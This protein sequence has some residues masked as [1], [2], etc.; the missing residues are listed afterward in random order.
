MCR[1]STKVPLDGNER[2]P[3][4][5]CESSAGRYKNTM[6]APRKHHNFQHLNIPTSQHIDFSTQHKQDSTPPNRCKDIMD[7]SRPSP[8]GT[9]HFFQLPAELRNTIYEYTLT[10]S[11]GVLCREEPSNNSGIFR[12]YAVP[13]MERDLPRKSASKIGMQQNSDR[14]SRRPWRPTSSN[15]FA[16]S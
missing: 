9:C 5:L 14:V 1:R 8:D 2:M 7:P 10:G 15:M 3:S 16:G 13:V 4:Q 11:R 6:R 12:F